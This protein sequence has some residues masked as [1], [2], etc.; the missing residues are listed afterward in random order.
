MIDQPDVAVVGAGPAGLMAATVAAQAGASVTVLEQ[1]SWAGGRLGLQVLPLQGP[2]SIY[3]DTNGVDLCR[4]LV[5]EATSAGAEM[6]QPS[7]PSIG[8][9]PGAGD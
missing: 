6:I 8:D 4:R 5:D 3:G 9:S 1:W 2:R 7:L